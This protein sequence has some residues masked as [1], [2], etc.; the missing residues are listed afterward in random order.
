MGNET[1]LGKISAVRFGK[2]DARLGLFL[3]LSGSS[4]VGTA[5]ETWDPVDIIP[6]GNH[7]WTEEDRD[8]ELSIIMRQISNLLHKAKVD[9]VND[10]LNIPVEITF[11]NMMLKSWRILEEVL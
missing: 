1:I 11:E 7:K 3:T 5:Y 9:N 4:A 6:E 10:L 2:Q 8:K